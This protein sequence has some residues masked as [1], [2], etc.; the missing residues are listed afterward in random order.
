[1]N[2]PLVLVSGPVETRS[3]Y[4]NHAR[5]IC[6]ALIEL[7]KYDVLI[8]SVPWGSTPMNALE[9]DNK[10]HQEIK[11][12]ILNNNQLP[13]QPDLHFHIVIPNEFQPIAKKNIGITAGIEATIPAPN[14]ID[15]INRM[16]LT[17]CTSEFT[18]QVFTNAEFTKK[19][20]DGSEVVHKIA[21]PMETL[22]E[23]F[24]EIYKTTTEFD[25]EV[26][27]AFEP[28]EE[29]FGF[30]YTGH[31]LQGGLGQDRKDTGMLIK[32][33]CETFKNQKNTPALILKTSG[34]TFS[35]IDRNEILNK[36]K[37]IKNSIRA[38]SLPNVYLIHG[39]F[40]DEQ[41]NQMYN[42]PKVNAHV[43]FTHGEGFGRP[44]LE[45][46][47]SGKPIAVSN[48]SGH[49]DFLHGSYC[50]LIPG[51]L[52]KVPKGAFPK[53]LFFEESQWFTVN[54]QIASQILKDIYNNYKKYKVKAQ[55]LK[56]YTQAFS[57][58]KMKE[59]LDELIEPLVDAVPKQVTLNLPKLNKVKKK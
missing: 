14:W 1:M 15:G 12:R 54:Y 23:G 37:D 25:K 11:S 42:H 33:F 6:R 47:Q 18:K 7:D 43:S 38:D 5:D 49:L 35:I 36:I 31:W 55:Q 41:M 30:L 8:N 28:V 4:G 56:V 46:A 17:I 51:S 13:K 19:N 29:D 24:E 59:R 39:N 3:G 52:T 48:W 50:S 53:E 10:H 44:L 34:A 26:E 9:D 21:K 16:D 20:P 45:A 57:F 2:K 58:E 27:E 40:T 22:F 32:V